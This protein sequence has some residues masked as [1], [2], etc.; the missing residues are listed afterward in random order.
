MHAPFPANCIMEHTRVQKGCWPRCA[1]PAPHSP[2]SQ[3]GGAAAPAQRDPPQPPPPARAQGRLPSPLCAGSTARARGQG[4]RARAPLAR[5][6]GRLGYFQATVQQN[7]RGLAGHRACAYS[8]PTGPAC[9]HP[10]PI[11]PLHVC[12]RPA[13]P[14]RC[15]H[16]STRAH[17][18]TQDLL[19][20]RGA[21]TRQGE[22]RAALL[23]A[24]WASHPRG[25]APGQP[26]G[27][28]YMAQS[29][30]AQWRLG[31]PS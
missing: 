5:M 1:H 27:R 23:R 20:C 30:R 16:T 26:T 11:L 28:Q 24:L 6:H 8:R 13:P 31:T 9:L 22:W 10:T 12:F 14:L 19:G 17:T 2:R 7:V 15:T 25:R 29:A 21:L 4:P 18:H 3:C